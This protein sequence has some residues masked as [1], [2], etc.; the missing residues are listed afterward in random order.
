VGSVVGA[1]E[2]SMVGS[3]VGF[4]SMILIGL[5]SPRNDDVSVTLSVLNLIFLDAL[6]LD[7]GDDKAVDWLFKLFSV[8]VRVVIRCSNLMFH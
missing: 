5:N 3:E 2:G 1:H 6:L 4:Q 8:V 7:R